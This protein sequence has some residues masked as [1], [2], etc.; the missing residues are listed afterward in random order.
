MD[1]QPPPG[2]VHVETKN[3]PIYPG[4]KY[5]GTYYSTYKHEWDDDAPRWGTRR[6]HV[7]RN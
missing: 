4:A 2:Y 1:R 3:V 6:D 7:D 5:G